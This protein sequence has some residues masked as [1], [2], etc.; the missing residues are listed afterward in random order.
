MES[1][2]LFDCIEHQLKHFP[3]EDMLAAKEKGVWKKYSTQEI[4]ETVNQLS[5]GL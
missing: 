1:K 4:S 3:K 2:R 5:A